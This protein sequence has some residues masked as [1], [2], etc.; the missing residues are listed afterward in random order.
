MTGTK[1]GAWLNVIAGVLLAMAPFV[2]RYDVM[3]DVATAEAVALGL[4]IGGIALWSALSTTAPAYLDYVL[5]ALGGWSVAA[6]FVLG[7]HSIV[8][9]A[10]NTDV[11]IGVAVALIA[12]M[13]H[14]YSSPVVRD[15]VAA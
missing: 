10:R 13:S 15:K 1:W 2:L 12:L 14:Y 5:A 3:S 9:V 11:M 8:E 6:P 7:Y 4:V